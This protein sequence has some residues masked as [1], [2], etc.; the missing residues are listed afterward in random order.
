M[1]LARDSGEW[2]DNLPTKD[3]VTE[4]LLLGQAT[5]GPVTIHSLYEAVQ[6]R[7]SAFQ[8][9]LQAYANVL[10]VKAPRSQPS[11]TAAHFAKPLYIQ[12]L[13]LLTLHGEQPSAASS[14]TKAILNHEQRYWA[15]ALN[16]NQSVAN[17]K[18]AKKLLALVTLAGNFRTARE[19][20]SFWRGV[21]DSNLSPREFSNLFD[22]LAPLYPGAQG[23][24]AIRPDL[25]GEELVSGAIVLAGGD[26][27]LDVVLGANSSQQMKEHALTILARVA[28]YRAEIQP[29]LTQAFTNNFSGLVPSL[30]KVA[31]EA[32]SCLPRLAEQ[33]FSHL[34]KN[35]QHSVAAQIKDL[36]TY[37]STAL[38]YLVCAADKVLFDHALKKASKVSHKK[39]AQTQSE[40]ARTATN[41]SASLARIGQHQLAKQ[42]TEQAVAIY[43][44]L[45]EESPQRYLPD[46]ATSLSNCAGH[47]SE[48]GEYQV[49]KQY[50]ERA[51]AIREQLAEESP[52]RYLPDL[53]TSLSNYAG[54]L[55]EVGEYQM[56]KQYAERALE[57]REQLAEESPQ[58]Y[59]PGLATSL[60]NYAS[61][62]SNV[63]EY[64]VAIESAE[65]AL[66]IREQLAEVSPQRYLS[67][68]ATSLSNYASHLSGVGEYQLAKQYAERA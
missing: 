11:L 7:Q 62:L 22:C 41:F 58:R 36:V 67:D 66:E 12:M 43:E 59:L 19:A 42:H 23:L 35:T 31:Q 25:L 3:T 38:N 64:Q 15:A 52:Q 29:A 18:Q 51:L 46:S 5:T 57:I 1:L 49:A 14:I 53:A 28:D 21:D 63:G 20:S 61:H 2:W 65:R 47:L 33:A 32:N 39:R 9:A 55:S 30:I 4:P 34:A 8:S 40:L 48:V 50:A 27:L 17:S 60:N 56:A 16:S 68:L 45:T 44:Q 37:D 10:S 24:Q 13:A 54:H 6:Q 26:T